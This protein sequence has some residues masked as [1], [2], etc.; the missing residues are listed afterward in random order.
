METN[1]RSS[2]LFLIACLVTVSL[3][4]GDA[5]AT[6]Q[7][8]GLFRSCSHSHD[9]C[10]YVSVT[11]SRCTERGDSGERCTGVSRGTC[12]TNLVCDFAGGVC[13]HNPPETGEV[14]GALLPCVSGL[15]CSR[16][17]DGRCNP[18]GQSG[19]SC[20]GFGQ[21]SCASGLKCDANRTCRHNPPEF[22]EPCGTGVSCVPELACSKEVAGRCEARDIAGETCSGINQGSCEAGLV[23]DFLRECRHNPPRLDEPCGPGVSCDDGLYCQAGTQICKNRKSIG[24]GC[25]IVNPCMKGLSC[26]ACFSGGCDFPFQCFPNASAGVITQQQ[27]LAIFTQKQARAAA[28]SGLAMTVAA[29]NGIVGLIGEAQ[30]FGVVYGP[31]GNYGCFSSICAGV[32]IDVAISHFV[33]FGFFSA[34]DNVAGMSTAIIEGVGAGV[35]SFS[36]SQIYERKSLDPFDLVGFPLSPIGTEDVFA[37]TISPDD[38]I[39]PFNPGT[40]VCETVVDTVIG[41]DGQISVPI[42]GNGDLEEREACDDGNILSGDGC[43]DV[44][45]VEALCGNG[46][47]D[48]GEGCDDGNP[49]SGDGCSSFCQ[50]EPRCGD[51]NLDPGE[52]CDDGNNLDGDVCSASCTIPPVLTTHVDLGG[53]VKAV[54]GTEI[55]AIALASGQFMFTCSPNGILSLAGLPR[56]NNGTVKRQIYADGFFPKIDILMA[57]RDDAVVMSRSGTCPDY[58]TSYDAG[59]FPGSAGKRINIAGKVLTQN[60]QTPICAM[61]LANGKHTFSCNGSGSYALNIPL[62]NNGQVKLQVYADGFA[63][64]TQV[65]DEFKTTNN[66]RMTRAAECQ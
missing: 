4:C 34:Y 48:T 38:I 51:G 35:A 1:Q 8:C 15:T 17:V 6:G 44:C 25:S 20:S 66:V 65:Y 49:F 56:E 9:Y 11:S 55:C 21:G 16:E 42:C 50:V 37:L 39:F 22:G 27:C 63:P 57:S 59:V 13:R 14:C 24:D 31:N 30:E 36:T 3:W 40:Y 26:E 62:D 52:E 7:S 12:K 33:S 19:D 29:G 23:C 5:Q 60:S 47:L 2:L 41:G 45:S 18:P 61:V 54:D 28:D 58:N 64:M 43:S 46:N 53:T 32:A 10:R